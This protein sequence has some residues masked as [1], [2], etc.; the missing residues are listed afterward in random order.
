TSSKRDWSSD[1]CSSDLLET[2]LNRGAFLAGSF[3][4]GK[5]HFMAVLHAVLRHDPH[6]RGH[7]DLQGIISAHDAELQGKN[8]LPLSFHFLDGRSMEQVLFDGYV[9]QIRELHP[10]AP[11]PAVYQ[12]DALLHDAD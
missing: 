10:E 2:G 3:G 7:R 6:A 12:A 9:K 1:V 8:F 5:S 4:A 11:L